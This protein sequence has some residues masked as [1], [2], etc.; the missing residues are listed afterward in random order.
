MPSNCRHLNFIVPGK[1]GRSALDSNQNRHYPFKRKASPQACKLNIC[2]VKT[3]TNLV[4]YAECRDCIEWGLLLK[5]ILSF[6]TEGSRG[7]WRAREEKLQ[8]LPLD[9]EI[10]ITSHSNPSLPLKRKISTSVSLDMLILSIW[11]FYFIFRT[12]KFT[13]PDMPF[14][15]PARVRLVNEN[16][17]L[18]TIYFPIHM[19]R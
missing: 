15:D 14:W 7:V 18:S 17:V 9:S 6:R 11:I 19:E 1:L 4:N 2:K 12:K 5:Q 3:C 10:V 16:V 13:N 8:R